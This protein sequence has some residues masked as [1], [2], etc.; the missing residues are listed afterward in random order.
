MNDERMPHFYTRGHREN[1]VRRS[2]AP[3]NILCA[4]GGGTIGGTL[5]RRKPAMRANLFRRFRANDLLAG[6][7]T[8]GALAL[9]LCH[10]LY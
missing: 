8:A 6:V 10:N 1:A 9:V 7:F 3:P 2:S 4:L 5:T